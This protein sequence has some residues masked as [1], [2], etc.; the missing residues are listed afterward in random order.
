[1]PLKVLEGRERSQRQLYEEKAQKIWANVPAEKLDPSKNVLGR[2]RI[3]RTLQLLKSAAFLQ[4][5]SLVDLGCGSGYLAFLLGS[6]GSHVKAV[7]V[8]N[9][10]MHHHV[11]VTFYHACLPYIALFNDT[12]DGVILSDVIAEIDPSLHRLAL[13]EVARLVKSDGWVLF[14]TPLD[15]TSEDARQKFLQ[16]IHTEFEIDGIVESY[17]RLY[18]VLLRWFKAPLRFVRASQNANYRCGHLAKR[19]G[20][21][22]LWFFLNSSKALAYF[23]RPWLPLCLPLLNTMHRSRTLLLSLERLS[24][25]IWGSGALTHII[26]LA[27]KRKI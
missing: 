18:I 8:V 23:W 5:G 15:L 7:D 14:S 11:Q 19:S 10:I 9:N 26:V 13:S 1:M 16:L 17:H 22:R 12:F 2:V 6:S 21:S 24:E 3:E 25:I 20:P 27:R 4:G